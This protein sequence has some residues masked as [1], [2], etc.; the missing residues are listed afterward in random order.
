MNRELHN[1][2]LTHQETGYNVLLA[3]DVWHNAQIELLAML[4]QSKA[5]LYLFDNIMQWCKQTFNTVKID[6]MNSKIVTRDKCIKNIRDQFD[7]HKISP[8][9]C[10]LK[11]NGS[12]KTIKLVIH[13]FKQSLYS[14]LSDNFLMSEDNLLLTADTLYS[15]E[16]SNMNHEILDDINTGSVYNNARNTC[17]DPNSI[18]VL[19]PIIFL[20]IRHTLI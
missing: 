4:K 2:K 8:V 12:L 5:P 3:N 19:C 18:D 13:D 9:Q 1:Q 20:L 15:K 16:L 17:L 11:L 7:I 14:L 6:D 10:D